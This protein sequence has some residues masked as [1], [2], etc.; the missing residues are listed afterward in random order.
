MTVADVFAEAAR[1]H[2]VGTAFGLLGE[3]NL[4]LVLAVRRAGL[5]WI[6]LRGEDA[7]VAAADGH[8]QGTGRPAMALVSQGPALANAVNPL[9]GARK[10][11]TPLVVVTGALADDQRD[12]PQWCDQA[13]L[14][15]ACGVRFVDARS[16]ADVEAAFAY[17]REERLPVVLQIPTAIQLGEPTPSSVAPGPSTPAPVAGP[18]PA[19]LDRA[20]DLL[21]AAQRPVVLAGRGAIAARDEAVALAARAGAWLATTLLAKG[22]FAGEPNDIGVTG[23]F[24]TVGNERIVADADLVLVLGAGLN[25]YTTRGGRLLGATTVVRVDRDPDAS[26]G[27]PAAAVELCGD[28]AAVARALTERLPSARPTVGPL[29]ADPPEPDDS[30]D[31]GLDLRAVSRLLDAALP[32]D[33]ALVTD[34]GYFTSE[35]AIA[36]A[37]R[38]PR[39]HAFPLHFGS[40]G[41]G[42]ATAIGLAAADP[43]VPTLCAVGDGGLCAS[44]GELES[45]ART[46]LPVVVAVFDDRAY[47][48]EVHE[49][50]HRGLAT[51]VAEFAP[52]DFAAV[53]R[54]LGI[55]AV[56]ARTAGDLDA[57]RAALAAPDGPLLVHFQLNPTVVTRWYRENVHA[58]P[59]E[60]RS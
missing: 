45:L 38:H 60:E 42:L 28:A 48:V 9:I 16:A 30:D 22:L 7:V 32:T 44:L 8:A 34:L 4:A 14:V 11:R 15:S 3:A 56:A 6:P 13:A 59:V 12:A 31:S 39:R 24:S 49:L 21:A 43:S 46:R 1:R 20:A 19:D 10:G 2:G 23:G 52:V 29:P 54:A 55:P 17:A 41:L 25:A 58:A 47:G 27:G 53:A 26:A 51:D 40:I 36:V 33:R 35:P 37:V 5:D 50:R 18:A 57:V